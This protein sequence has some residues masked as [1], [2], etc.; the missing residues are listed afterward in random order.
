MDNPLTVVANPFNDVI[1]GHT[2]LE[3]VACPGAGL[4]FLKSHDLLDQ[5]LL[6]QTVADCD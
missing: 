4:C 6:S 1:P 3:N 5:H 2:H